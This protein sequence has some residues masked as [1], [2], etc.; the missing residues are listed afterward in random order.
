MK[1]L[2]YTNFHYNSLNV[3]RQKFAKYL[4]F[5]FSLSK[6]WEN[7][8]KSWKKNYFPY[9]MCPCT[10]RI[11][12]FNDFSSLRCKKPRTKQ[13]GACNILCFKY[14]FNLLLIVFEQNMFSK[15]VEVLQSKM[16]NSL[17][18]NSNL[19][20]MLLQSLKSIF[21]SCFCTGVCRVFSTLNLSHNEILV[22]IKIAI[23]N[24]L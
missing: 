12:V 15:L 20:E 21:F 13:R 23:F 14:F 19:L 2:L 16:N 10:N 4:L 24:T 11:G 1:V 17:L 22:A 9:F 8:G 3:L 18:D 5:N 7:E 6:Y